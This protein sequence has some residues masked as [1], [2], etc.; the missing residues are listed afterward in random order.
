LSRP[1]R[2]HQYVAHLPVAGDTRPVPDQAKGKRR[3]FVFADADGIVKLR[4][5]ILEPCS[6]FGLERLQIAR[7]LP[8]LRVVPGAQLR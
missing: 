7:P 4:H 2:L 3:L 6:G 5:P 8:S 1:R